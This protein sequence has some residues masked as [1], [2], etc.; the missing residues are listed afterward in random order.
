MQITSFYYFLF[1]TCMVCI[2]YL[3]PKSFQWVWLLIASLLFYACS[4]VPWT[5]L[6]I[7]L[8]T[9]VAY[10]AALA[11][12][13]LKKQNKTIA[14]KW[15]LAV[16]I[17]LN[18]LVWFRLKGCDIYIPILEALQLKIPSEAAAALGMGYYTAQII[19][20]LL[21]CYWDTIEP[22]RNPLKLFLFL[23]FFPQL[24]SGP[25][26][27]FDQMKALYTGHTFSI[28]TVAHGCQRILY[29]VMKKLVIAE[30]AGVIINAIWAGQDTYTGF[31]LWIAFLLFPIQMYADFSGCMDIVL[32]TAE[33]FDIH[34]A[35]NFNNPFLSRSSQEFWQRW[36]ITLGTW[37]KDYVLY[38]L[39]KS[40]LFVR[41]GKSVKKRFGK[42]AGKKIP[43]T[44]GMFVLWMVMGIWHGGMKYIVG[45]SLWYWLLLTLSD[46]I[47]PV[48]NKHIKPKTETF[49]R[50]LLQRSRTYLIYATGAIFFRA[51]DMTA[52]FEFIKGLGRTF[53]HPN[54]WIFFDGSIFNTG[55]APIDLKVLIFSTGIVLIVGLLR[56]KYGY[57]RTWM[58][59]QEIWFRWASWIGLFLLVLIF[60]AYGPGYNAAA[61]LYKGF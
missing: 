13:K 46:L 60:G 5:I 38:P 18:V 1:L 54:L 2:F 10:A 4:A 42:K 7:A 51:P 55:I 58:D 36:H 19:G 48:I 20:Y 31:Y 12:E 3:F 45:V 37:A 26:S 27:R 28:E 49:S 43:V 34:L 8:S 17:G 56:E 21:D 29:G 39:L 25:I 15:I 16:S 53:F 9:A 14:V 47:L 61:F 11:I 57:A 22:E 50:R 52:A 6:Y 44:V 30:N 32:G 23:S 35:E 33:L 40:N 41:F 59:Q 24:I